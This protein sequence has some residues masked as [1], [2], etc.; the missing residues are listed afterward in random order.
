MSCLVSD[1]GVGVTVHLKWIRP[2]QFS[3]NIATDH[4][5]LSVMDADLQRALQ[6]HPPL[7]PTVDFPPQK[8]PPLHPT[9][10]HGGLPSAHQLAEDPSQGGWPGKGQ[11]AEPGSPGSLIRGSLCG[12]PPWLLQA[13]H[14]RGGGRREGKQPGSSPGGRAWGAGLVPSLL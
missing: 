7:H 2:A 10:P 3:N 6:K 9:V 4:C 8:R 13:A 12:R 1:L 5:A 11:F 14:S